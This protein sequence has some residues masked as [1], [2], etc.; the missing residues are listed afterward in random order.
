MEMTVKQNINT[1]S[2]VLKHKIAVGATALLEGREFLLESDVELYTMV[3]LVNNFIEENLLELVEQDER[4]FPSILEETI[5][6][7]FM[8]LMTTY[9]YENTYYEIVSIVLDYLNTQEIRQ[10]TMIGLINHLIDVFADQNWEDMEYFFTELK[11]KG[12]KYLA[13]MANTLNQPKEENKE[14]KVVTRAKIEEFEGASDN[15]KE[16]IQKFQRES[17]EIKKQNNE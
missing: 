7:F 9:D 6:P 8:E 11:D 15:I 16:L 17:E 2:I 14:K 3:S 12:S 13:D 4:D 1:K 10:N 5:E